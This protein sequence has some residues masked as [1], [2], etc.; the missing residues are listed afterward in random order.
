MARVNSFV[1]RSPLPA[2]PTKGAF[3]QSQADRNVSGCG[4]CDWHSATAELRAASSE[5]ALPIHDFCLLDSDCVSQAGFERRSA[6]LLAVL[7]ASEMIRP[8]SHLHLQNHASSLVTTSPSPLHLHLLSIESLRRF[9]SAVALLSFGSVIVLA[10][11]FASPHLSETISG[12]LFEPSSHRSTPQQRRQSTHLR[13]SILVYVRL[14]SHQSQFFSIQ[15][16]C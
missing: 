9:T 6:C 13:F 3:R 16:R 8:S 11:P 4:G 12:L 7:A 1:R 15:T 14:H 5:R 2:E 10:P